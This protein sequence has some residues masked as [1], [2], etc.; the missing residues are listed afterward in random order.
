M[1]TCATCGLLSDRLFLTDRWI[2]ALIDLGQDDLVDRYHKHSVLRQG[3][4]DRYCSRQ[5]HNMLHLRECL[6]CLDLISGRNPLVELAIFYH[7][8][9]VQADSSHPSYELASA[10]KAQQDLKG[11]LPV[12]DVQTVH[13]L[14]LATAFGAEA[15]NPDEKLMQDVDLAILGADP[16]RF[17]DYDLGIRREYPSV[18]DQDFKQGRIA[19]LQGLLDRPTIYHSA[20]L[21][22]TLEEKARKNINEALRYYNDLQVG[23]SA[24]NKSLGF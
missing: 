1:R 24:L 8:Y 3:V 19:V 16:G 6:A 13:E 18:L 22:R 15:R 20:Y 4:L 11:V 9:Y 7:D 12:E 10:N 14:I 5:Y 17:R 2:Q 21:R 23:Q